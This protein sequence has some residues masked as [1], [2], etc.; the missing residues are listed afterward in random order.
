MHSIEESL[1][2]IDTAIELVELIAKQD[3]A[4]YVSTESI[5]M[6]ARLI[7]DELAYRSGI[8]RD[9]LKLTKGK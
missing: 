6:L 3:I 7:R 9:E 1:N 2:S 4:D 8:I 5:S